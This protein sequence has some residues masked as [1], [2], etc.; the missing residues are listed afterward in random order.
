MFVKVVSRALFSE[1][2][3][4]KPSSERYQYLNRDSNQ[5]PADTAC[6]F[7]CLHTQQVMIYALFLHE[8]LLQVSADTCRRL[9]LPPNPHQ[10]PEAVVVYVIGAEKTIL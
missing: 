1:G 7:R 10:A 5:Q 9:V 3:M 8:N 4:A 6:I 2:I